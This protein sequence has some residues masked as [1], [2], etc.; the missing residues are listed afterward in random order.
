MG[1]AFVLGRCSGRPAAAS[2]HSARPCALPPSRLFGAPARSADRSA[3]VSVWQAPRY[4]APRS[5]V[6]RRATSQDDAAGDVEDDADA[7][8]EV[9]PVRPFPHPP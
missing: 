1:M 5:L 2:A 6:V 3:S 7:P 9:R 8:P 4:A